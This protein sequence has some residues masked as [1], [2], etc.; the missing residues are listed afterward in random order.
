MYRDDIQG[1]KY[2]VYLEQILVI[3]ILKELKKDV[4]EETKKRYISSRLQRINHINLNINEYINNIIA[5]NQS[6]IDRV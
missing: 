6:F 2:Y 1:L 3:E 5:T 4:K